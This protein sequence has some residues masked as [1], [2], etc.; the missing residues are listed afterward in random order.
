MA[1][2]LHKLVEEG[3]PEVVERLGRWL[4]YA[5]FWLTTAI[6]ALWF[7]RT[8]LVYGTLVIVPPLVLLFSAKFRGLGRVSTTLL[9]IA[10]LAAMVPTFFLG[11][12]KAV[13]D[14]H[15]GLIFVGFLVF[16]IWGAAYPAMLDKFDERFQLSRHDDPRR[17]LPKEERNQLALLRVLL[18]KIVMATVAMLVVDATV[19]VILSLVA[20][21]LRN[22]W[23]AAV[24]GVACLIE[25]VAELDGLNL[26]FRFD[27]MEIAAGLLAAMMWWDA[28]KNPLWDRRVR[29]GVGR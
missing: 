2:G 28:V 27:P 18:V 21:L 16:L 4:L 10:G 17:K 12:Y 9:V 11:K 6:L 23:S 26:V 25:S 20:L 19:V 13:E 14:G 5:V 29:P 15:T 3:V 24:V 1:D 8:G 22:H 7:L